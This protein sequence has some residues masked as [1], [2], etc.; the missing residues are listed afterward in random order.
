M[1]LRFRIIV[2]CLLI[3]GVI[4]VWSIFKGYSHVDNFTSLEKYERYLREAYPRIEHVSTDTLQALLNGSGNLLLIDCR[5]PEEYQVSRI[6]NAVNL[7][8][9][10]AV[11][12]YLK[13]LEEPPSSIVIYSAVGKRSVEICRQLEQGDGEISIKNYTGS[14]FDWANQALPLVNAADQPTKEIHFYQDRWARFL[15][16]EL[17]QVGK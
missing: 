14:I 5:E 4:A 13:Q 2:G 12:N 15:D 9:T 7:S 10:D 16:E 8:T 6:S 11:T 17:Q 1:S 3:F